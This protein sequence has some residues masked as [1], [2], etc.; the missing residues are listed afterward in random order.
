MMFNGFDDTSTPYAHT[1]DDT[2]KK[3]TRKLLLKHLHPQQTIIIASLKNV[4]SF[5]IYYNTAKATSNT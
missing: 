3:S 2:L 4:R 5:G 1:S